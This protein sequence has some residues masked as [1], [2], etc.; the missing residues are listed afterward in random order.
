MQKN[1]T[2]IT[3]LEKIDLDKSPKS[4]TLSFLLNYSKS[5]EVKKTKKGY[6]E[7]LKN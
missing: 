1:A 7:Y 4:E 6:V 5:L 3:S 2:P